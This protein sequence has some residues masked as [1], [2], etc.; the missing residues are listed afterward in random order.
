M[1]AAIDPMDSDLR[2]RRRYSLYAPI[3]GLLVAP[4]RASRR[5]A[6]AALSL[7]AGD[8]LLLVGCG[9]G[10]DLEFIPDGVPVSGIDVTPAMV[11]RARRRAR[12]LGRTAAFVVGDARSLPYADGSFDAVALHLILAVAPEP[13]RIVRETHRVLRDR[14]RISVFDKF[15][16]AGRTPSIPRRLLN[17]VATALFSDL[18][19]Q[20]EPLLETGPFTIIADD[21]ADFGGSYRRLLAIRGRA[22]LPISRAR[23]GRSGG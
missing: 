20:V 11:S 22:P 2:N 16:P 9:P 10:S 18:N 4:L 1:P 15:L 7:R 21:P 5:A 3:Y 19:R 23:G 8:R 12:Q 14:G 17:R 13:E 6:I